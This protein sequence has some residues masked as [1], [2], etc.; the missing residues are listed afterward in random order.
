MA[1]PF[2]DAGH[3]ADACVVRYEER[4]GA[5]LEPWKKEERRVAVMLLVVP[6]MVF[7]WKVGSY[8]ISR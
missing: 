5:C 8:L 4:R 1:W 3:G 2:P 6:V 7:L